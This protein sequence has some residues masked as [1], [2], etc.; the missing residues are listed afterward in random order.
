MLKL[1]IEIVCD[2]WISLLVNFCALSESFYL[3]IYTQLPGN[4]VSLVTQV[5]ALSVAMCL[6][7]LGLVPS[8]AVLIH[9]C[10]RTHT[11]T[12]HTHSHHTHV[13]HACTHAHHSYIHT[14]HM[15]NMQAHTCTHA[16]HIYIHTTHMYNMH[17][18]AHTHAHHTY[19]HT[20]HMYNMHAQPPTYAHYTH[21]HTTHTHSHPYMCLMHWKQ[22]AF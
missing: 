2:S 9:K 4:T 3:Q 16:H 21:V 14:T 15:Y 17:A 1:P 22:Y 13:Q 8:T 12:P 18:H 6:V 20:T 11:C 19:I 7:L 5:V 10:T